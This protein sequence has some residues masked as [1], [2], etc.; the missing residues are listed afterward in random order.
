MDDLERRLRGLLKGEHSSLTI[1]FNEDHAPNYMTAAEYEATEPGDDWV[2]ETEREK[3]LE[4]NTVWS[5]QWYPQTP[6]GFCRLKASS[7]GALVEALQDQ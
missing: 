2:S 4:N 6:V 7:L 5:I 3:A 1:G